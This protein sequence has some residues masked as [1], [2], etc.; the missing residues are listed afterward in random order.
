L[1]TRFKRR[2]YDNDLRHKGK[3]EFLKV[4]S[5]AGLEPATRRL[6]TTLAFAS[7]QKLWRC[8][9]DWLIA[10]SFIC[11]GVRRT[12]SEGFLLI[13]QLTFIKMLIDK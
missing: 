13:Y 6:P 11:L 2:I 9:L 7:R 1:R 5:R 8:S 3:E 4:V 12:V 10:H